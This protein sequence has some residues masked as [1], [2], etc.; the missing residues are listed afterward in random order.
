MSPQLWTVIRYLGTALFAGLAAAILYWP[1]QH[2]IAI[3]LAVLGAVGFH[4]VPISTA[5]YQAVMKQP[6]AQK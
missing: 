2:W 3:A 1:D 6:G 5:A 4:A